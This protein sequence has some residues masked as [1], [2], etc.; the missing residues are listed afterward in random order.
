MSDYRHLRVSR[1]DKI[2]TV[3]LDRP[4][5][6]NALN[7]EMMADLADVA[8]RLRKDTGLRAIILTGAKSFFS[9][10]AD[11]SMVS[12]AIETKSDA[13]IMTL[14]D[15]LRAGPEMCDLWAAIE[16]PTIAAI[17]G[18][19]VGGA[20]SLALACDFRIA[21]ANAFMR[22]PEVPYG[23]NMSW[24]TLP[25]LVSLM[26]PS[27]SKEMT[28]FGEPIAS[29]RLLQWGAID[30]RVESGQAL[31]EAQTFAEKIS[32]LPPLAVRI[33]KEAIDAVATSGHAA[34]TFAD[35]DQ[36]LLTLM[37]GIRTRKNG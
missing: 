24:H 20:V 18:F 31:A 25:R 6:K 17:E 10:G 27:R 3:Q 16:V 23:M 32:A 4:E 26:G 12:E 5:A 34:A 11:L 37:S 35:R 1:T 21:G 15:Q 30:R 8:I 36:F 14:R 9:A 29:D 13:D 7:A 22:L 19:C 28:I 33:T 2:A